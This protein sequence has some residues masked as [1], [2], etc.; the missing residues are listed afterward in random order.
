MSKNQTLFNCF[1][2][3]VLVAF[4]SLLSGCG[5]QQA[6]YSSIELV[7]VSGV[8]ILDGTPVPDAVVMFEDLK[9][10]LK[11]YGLTDSSGKYQLQFD[12]VVNGTMPGEKKVVV[13]TTMKVLGVNSN[14][15][16]G[17]SSEEG[18]SAE[19]QEKAVEMIPDAYREE[20][21]LRVVVEK[22]STTF[23]FD[24]ASDGSTTGPV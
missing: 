9:T 3:A 22:T 14:S 12:S 23:D 19:P 16:G 2:A 13:S 24:L 6:D 11:S 20:T 15:E 21:K 18:E 8:I 4:L 10:G 1:S 7:E 5:P 17:E